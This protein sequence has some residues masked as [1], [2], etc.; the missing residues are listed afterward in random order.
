MKKLLLVLALLVLLVA[1]SS[2]PSDAEC[3]GAKQQMTT[4]DVSE[5]E[6]Y[7]EHRDSVARPLNGVEVNL[8]LN[9]EYAPDTVGF[10]LKECIE[11]GWDY[12]AWRF[13]E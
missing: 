11:N 13:P 8:I 6:T 3:I 2:G 4:L 7:Q 9:N 10:V 12:R 1:C 5:T